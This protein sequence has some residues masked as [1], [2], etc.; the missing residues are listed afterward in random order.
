MAPQ[1]QSERQETTD[2]RAATDRRRKLTALCL[3]CDDAN[4]TRFAGF[5]GRV[6]ARITMA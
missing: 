1:L 2:E 5:D 3:V 6:E 4:G